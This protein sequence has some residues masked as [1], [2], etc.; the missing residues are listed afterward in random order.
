MNFSDC[1]F[2]FCLQMDKNVNLNA[3]LSS[4]FNEGVSFIKSFVFGG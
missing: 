3:C 4:F 2:C 1:I